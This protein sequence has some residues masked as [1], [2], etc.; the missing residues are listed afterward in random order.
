VTF[1]ALYTN[2]LR[3]LP[4]VIAKDCPDTEHAGDWLAF[5]VGQ[6][7]H[8][9]DY[10]ASIADTYGIAN[11]QTGVPQDASSSAPVS[12]SASSSSP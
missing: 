11:A 4:S 6:V 3:S 12:S 1:Y 8:I 9:V 7:E 2:L 5:M 10:Y